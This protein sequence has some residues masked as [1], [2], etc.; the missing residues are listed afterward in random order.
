MSKIKLEILDNI[1][2]RISGKT[3][4]RG[5]YLPEYAET[6]T[7]GDGVLIN[8]GNA[9]LYLRPIIEVNQTCPIRQVMPFK[10][11]RKWTDF[12]DANGDNFPDFQTFTDFVNEMVCIPDNSTPPTAD[13]LSYRALLT[14]QISNAPTA[15]VKQNTTGVTISYAYSTVGE[16][17]INFSSA[18][19][20]ET[21]WGFIQGAGNNSSLAS[22][23]CSYVSPT[24]LKLENFDLGSVGVGQSYASVADSKTNGIMIN[25]LIIIEIYN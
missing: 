10:S 21:N 25:Q 3:Y 16:Y 17:L 5:N 19:L 24:Q 11:P 18:I 20:T 7:D 1:A 4:P 6:A 14:Q 8:E 22:L 9:N 12:V 23:W 2:F 13:F 15:S